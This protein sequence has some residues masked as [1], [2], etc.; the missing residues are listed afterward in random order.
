MDTF[1]L[2]R[3]ALAQTEN[4]PDKA[5]LDAVHHRAGRILA[6]VQTVVDVLTRPTAAG[7]SSRSPTSPR[8]A[9]LSPSGASSSAASRCTTRA[10]RWS[11][12]RSSSRRSPLMR[13]GTRWSPDR[14]RC[15]SRST[16][17]TPAT[18]RSPTSPTTS[19]LS[20]T[21]SSGTRSCGTRSTSP[22]CG[23]F[24]PRQ[25]LPRS[26]GSPHD[27]A[28]ERYNLLLHATRYGDIPEVIVSGD[29]ALQ[30]VTGAGLGGRLI[31][32]RSPTTVASSPC[33]TR[34]W[35]RIR[36]EAPEDEPSPSPSPDEPEQED[37]EP[38][39]G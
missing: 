3:N 6:A 10:S 32:L 31:A 27:H 25:S 21:W 15:W 24:G 39:A 2:I 22:A 17:P 26:N 28:T 13:S 30:S 8:R 7:T 1:S 34:S 12:R 23:S 9:R 20:R 38:E 18:T 11:R 35:E 14:A 36:E 4:D 16:T 37:D 5:G 19:S 29:A 33:A